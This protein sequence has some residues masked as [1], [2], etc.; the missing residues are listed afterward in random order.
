MIYC[1]FAIWLFAIVLAARGVLRLLAGMLKPRVVDWIVLPGTLA[2]ELARYLA[3]LLTGGEF[4][5]RKLVGDSD[6][7]DAAPAGVPYLTPLLTG[8]LPLA[9]C[10]GLTVLLNATFDSQVYRHYEAS[11][12]DA[13][14][15]FS[16]SNE[17]V[18]QILRN[19]VDL[20]EFVTAA[21]QAKL[22]QWPWQNWKGWLLMYL[23]ACL[24]LRT[25][26]AS[27]PLRP[28]LLGMA[29]IAGLAAGVAAIF[30]ENAQWL[31]SV[32]PLLSFT[33]SVALALLAATLCIRGLVALSLALTGRGP[34]PQPKRRAPRRHAARE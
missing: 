27:R 33:W 20:L 15:E 2:S 12:R 25:A 5:S 9:A 13:A 30:S 1:A 29:I 26:P 14:K 3:C 23:T 18:W 28:T 19:Q 22:S 11:G 17:C 21:A 24:V 31:H 8:L 34:E 6:T 32:W 16:A 10:L 4:R 7:D